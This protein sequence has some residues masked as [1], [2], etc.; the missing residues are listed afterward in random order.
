MPAMHRLRPGAARLGEGLFRDRFEAN[1]RYI[2]GLRTEAVLQSHYHEAGLLNRIVGQ[3]PG[4]GD[5]LHWG[6]DAV[7]CHLRGH[8]AGHWLSALAKTV[9]ATGDA[10]VRLRLDHAVAELARCQRVNGGEWV[11]SIP[12]KYLRWISGELPRQQIW[13]PHYTI[14]KTLMG[15]MDAHAYAGCE[16]ALDVARNFAKWFARW[17]SGFTR[18]QM[19]DILDVETGGMLE[20]WACL[21]AATGDPEHLELMRRYDRP[22]LFEPLLEGRDVLT[23]LHANTTIPEAQGAARAYEVTGEERWR[24]VVEAYWR[25][26]VTERGTFATGGQTAGEIWCPPHAFAARLGDKNQE[27]CTVYNMIRLADYLLRWTGEAQYAD[28]IERNLYNGI[29]AQQHPATGMVSYFLPLEPG[30]RKKWGHPTRDFWCCHGTLVQAQA[31]YPEWAWYAMPDGPVLAQY[32]PGEAEWQAPD[33]SP[34]RLSLAA[35]PT[36]GSSTENGAPAGETHRPGWWWHELRITCD[37][38]VEFTLRLRLP[39]WLAG[40]PELTVNGRPHP[41]E[42]APGSFTSIRRNWR[43]DT[44]TLRLPKRLRTE[45]IPDAPDMVA[46]LDGP[47]VLAGLCDE[48]RAL[49]GDARQPE[50]L[51]V[52]DNEREWGIWLPGYRAVGQQRGLRFRP[53]HAIVDEPYTVYFPVRPER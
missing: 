16:Q 51:L 44:L 30:A 36:L 5:D 33:G 7:T 15:L 8:F 43:D 12:E 19:D 37:R 28:T 45:A 25:C 39:E 2:L 41:L 52:P 42:G 3:K 10:E 20:A 38:P 29:L 27:H 18:E 47:C 24:R 53:L 46:F 14:H 6:W 35:H 48:E 22:R 13:A 50:A 21:Y 4:D 34:V 32:I 9:A 31:S 11:A 26:A 23:N 40:R 17:T 1:R 49:V